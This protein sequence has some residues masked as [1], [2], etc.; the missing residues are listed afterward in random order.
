MCKLGCM[1]SRKEI[2]QKIFN[3]EYMQ[4]FI[5]ISEIEKETRITKRLEQHFK[6]R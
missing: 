5:P 6:K 1:K 2:N 3:Q 4:I